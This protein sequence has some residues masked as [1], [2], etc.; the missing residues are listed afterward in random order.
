[1]VGVI[2]YGEEI[3]ISI[4]VGTPGHLIILSRLLRGEKRV[5][6]IDDTFGAVGEE[7]TDALRVA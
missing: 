3:Y 7:S 6:S 5:Q 4:R 2:G 1:M